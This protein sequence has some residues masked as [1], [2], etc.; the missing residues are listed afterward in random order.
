[1]AYCEAIDEY[2]KLVKSE[3]ADSR[4]NTVTSTQ[5]LVA[6]K[7]MLRSDAT[8]RRKS[9]TMNEIEKSGRR[10]ETH[11]SQTMRTEPYR[12]PQ[13]QRESKSFLILTHTK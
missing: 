8:I 11:P 5:E 3:E 4:R 13:G 9:P 7:N 1:M 6:F 2:A 10:K 12:R